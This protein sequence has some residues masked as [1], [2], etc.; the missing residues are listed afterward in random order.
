MVRFILV[1]KLSFVKKFT[2]YEFRIAMFLMEKISLPFLFCG[3]K[4]VFRA[5]WV[6]II[7]YWIKYL[8]LRLFC[9]LISSRLV[10]KQTDL[11]RR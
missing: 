3:F 10:K 2:L 4:T 1:L 6:F 11:I 9:E 7:C 8:K 5:Y